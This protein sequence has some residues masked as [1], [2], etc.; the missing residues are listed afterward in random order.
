MTVTNFLRVFTYKMAA[1]IN[2]H[3][4]GAKLRHCRPMYT[5]ALTVMFHPP[6]CVV[7][8]TSL[9][10]QIGS[11]GQRIDR[12]ASVALGFGEKRKKLLVSFSKRFITQFSM[13]FF[14]RTAS[15]SEWLR[16]SVPTSILPARRYASAVLTGNYSLKSVCLCFCHTLV[17]HQNC[18]F[19]PVSEPNCCNCNCNCN[20]GICIASASGRLR[21]HHKAI[22][23]QSASQCP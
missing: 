11:T 12:F 23:H 1:K 22:N 4:Y 8:V 7:T 14:P 16:T 20:W 19:I 6:L 5:I 10:L 15:F 2:W 17:F 13:L 21:A 9:H 3:R 18:W